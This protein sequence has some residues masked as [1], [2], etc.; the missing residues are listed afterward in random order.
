MHRHFIL[1]IGILWA[2]AGVLGIVTGILP[3]W[4]GIA[5]IIVGVMMIV[6]HF[7][8]RTVYK[9]VPWLTAI[10]VTVVFFGALY[11]SGLSTN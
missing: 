9:K 8:F 11:I 7:R 2:V 4:T 5:P 3:W 10:A 6:A 1:F